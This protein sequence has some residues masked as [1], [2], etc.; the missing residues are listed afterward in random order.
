MNQ[1]KALIAANWKMYKTLAEAASFT[2]SL[3]GEVAPLRI[4]E[5]SLLLLYRP[6]RSFGNDNGAQTF[7][8]ASQNCHMGRP[9]EPSRR[10]FRR[11]VERNVGC[12]YVIF[13]ALREETA[14]RRNK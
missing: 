11:Y 3:Q 13:G 12:D 7:K 2:E 9:K 5:V 8:L 1:R 6:C 10:S 4:G 14:V